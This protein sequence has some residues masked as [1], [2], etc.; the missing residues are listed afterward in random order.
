MTTLRYVI[1]GGVQGRERLR[2]LSDV[3]GPPTRALLARVGVPAGASCLDVGCGGGDVTVEL[4]RAAGPSGRVLGVDLD[5]VALDLARRENE[6]ETNVRFEAHDLTT[7]EPMESFDVVYARFL[8]THLADP[9]RLLATL[10]R[11]LRPGGVMVVEDVDFRGHLAEPPCPAL[12]RFV[13]LYTASVRKRGADPN[14]GPRLPRLLGD[15]GFADVGVALAHPVAM[16]GGIKLLTCITLESIAD[17]VLA[18]G[19]ATAGALQATIDELAA[20][21]R[22]PQTVHAGPRIF[23]AWGRVG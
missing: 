21:A 10:R 18:D 14:I 3:M 17:A 11:H 20:F 12:D 1:R 2:L 4:A 13:A 8:L 19:F 7:W 16:Q 6:R 15:A 22:D 5:E 23:Q 9:G